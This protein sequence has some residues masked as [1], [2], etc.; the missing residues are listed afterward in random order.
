M[1]NNFSFPLLLVIICIFAI[2]SGCIENNYKSN[3][4]L[5]KTTEE[6]SRQIAEAY[7]RDLNSYRT[8]NLTEPVLTETREL[9]CSSCWQ[10][11]YKFDLVSKKDPDVIDTATVTVTVVKGETVDTV[12]AQGG[13]Y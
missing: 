4:E 9:N 6:K 1:K 7:V 11:I 10:F 13:R 12:Y 8:C 3:S 2:I 5:H